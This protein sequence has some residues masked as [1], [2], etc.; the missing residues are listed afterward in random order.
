VAQAIERVIDSFAAE[1][2]DE[3]QIFVQPM[4]ERVAMAGVAFSR[5]PSGGP[6]FVI[7]YD[8]RSGL[9]DRVTAGV[10]DNLETFFASSRGL[11]PAHH[12]WH[13]S[14]LWSAS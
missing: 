14:S 8:D 12:R 3:D 9:T 7:N 13:R 2:S 1:G 4:L 11:M 6:Y 10:G 5:N